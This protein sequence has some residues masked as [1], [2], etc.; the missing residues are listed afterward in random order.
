MKYLDVF[1]S[2]S[3]DIKYIVFTI[4]STQ[5]AVGFVPCIQQLLQTL[6]GHTSLLHI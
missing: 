3:T 5:S 4:V 2:S 1:F 6:E